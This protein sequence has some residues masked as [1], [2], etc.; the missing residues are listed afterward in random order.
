[1]LIIFC[2]LYDLRLTSIRGVQL[3]PDVV[4]PVKHG[5][6]GEDGE[7][8]EDGSHDVEEGADGEQDHSLG[9]FHYA[10]RAGKVSRFG[11]GPGV[12]DEC[13]TQEGERREDDHTR[14]TSIQIVNEKS[15][16]QKK[17]RVTV[18]NGVEEAAEDR[19]LSCFPGDNPVEKIEE[20]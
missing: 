6:V 16:H 14:L 1:M 18:Q 17:I 13:N 11:P 12:G 2:I 3:L 7:D 8:P 19:H 5:D 15:H 20:T 9:P 4:N 10:D